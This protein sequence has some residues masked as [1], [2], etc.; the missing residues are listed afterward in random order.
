MVTSFSNRRRFVDYH[1]HSTFSCDAQDTLD[2]MCLQAMKIGLEE[3]AFTEHADFEH[4]DS[5]YR[6]LEP[7]A[8]F[9]AIESARERYGDRLTI[10]AGVEVGE[11]HRYPDETAQL[12]NKF[13]FD[14]VLG[15][16]HWV[17]EYP[18]FSSKFFEGRPAKEAWRSYFE[19]L[20]QMCE[21]GD[22]DVLGHLDLPKRHVNAFDPE[23]YADLIRDAL[24]HLIQRGIGLEINCSG[25]RYP[26]RE[27]LPGSKVV[28]W[29]RELGGDLLTVGTDAHKTSHLGGGFEHALGMAREAGF[30]AIT[31][32]HQRQPQRTAISI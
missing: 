19:E 9:R 32:F 21:A 15:S 2:A 6:Y 31:L 29:Y 12:L 13:P 11:P 18:C 22:F 30:S 17:N 8:Y 5:C 26:M 25:L 3:I 10:R 14:F 16:L 4:L 23:P 24:Q 28:Q 27:P 20:V 1:T 7:A